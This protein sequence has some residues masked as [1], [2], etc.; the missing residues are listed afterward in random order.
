VLRELPIRNF[1]ARSL[2][3]WVFLCK[4]GTEYCVPFLPGIRRISTLWQDQHI[5]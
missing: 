3:M 1:Y 5:E 2:I 4:V